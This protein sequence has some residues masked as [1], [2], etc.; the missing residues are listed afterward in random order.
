MKKLSLSSLEQAG[1][2]AC[3][4]QRIQTAAAQMVEDNITPAQV[5]VA[6]RRGIVI[7]HQA[8]G[9]LG[10]EPDAAELAVDALFPLCSITKLFTAT[11][12]MMLV[13][14]GK[15]GLNR[16]VSDYIPEFTGEGKSKVCVH[17]LLTHTSG[18]D[19][20]VIRLN[21][22]A[23]L[24]KEEFPASEPN[25]D[26]EIHQ[27]LYGGYDA[28][29]SFE[30]GTVMSYCGY[31]YELL[32][33][34]IRRTSGQAYDEFVKE[35]IFEPLGM[36]NTYY[37]VPQEARSRVV[38]RI[39]EAACAEWIE[40]EDQLNSV[41][42]GGG[43]YSTALDLAV[44]GQMFLNGGIYNGTRLLSPVTVKEMTRNQ[45]P[46]VSSQYR[47]EVFPEAYWG[48]GWAI[49]GTKRDGGDLFSPEAYSH[50]GAAGPFLCV[51]PVYQ[52]VTVHFSVELDHQKPFKNMYVDYFNNT[53]LAAITDL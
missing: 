53:V 52:T 9:T 17:H 25:Q 2:S 39:P 12:V 23:K 7:V 13:E 22:T 30:P 5:I 44:F 15:I 6:A 42:A 45:I 8:N 26:P 14:Q 19:V 10:P 18:L 33:E 35:S 43:A 31:G 47:D 1:V 49:N 50:W 51:D 4:V 27:Y 48:Y 40:T 24:A 46:G 36:E 3:G 16:P 34:I 32:G 37:R 20:E 29:L 21:G 41:S 11:A 28:P 38:R